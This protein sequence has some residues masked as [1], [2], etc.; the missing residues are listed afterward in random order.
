MLVIFPWISKK[1][2]SMICFT[3]TV[4]LEISRSSALRGP[5]PFASL[6]LKILAMRRMPSVEG[7]LLYITPFLERTLIL[8]HLSYH[9]FLFLLFAGMGIILT[10]N[11]FAVRCPKEVGDA[12]TLGA[13]E[14]GTETETEV[15]SFVLL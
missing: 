10:R 9:I 7:T 12:A 6:A 1:V 5:L 11:A 2:K 15:G 3:N 13:T 4:E 14:I 8:L